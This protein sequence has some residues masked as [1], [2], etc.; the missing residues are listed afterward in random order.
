MILGIINK[1]NSKNSFDKCVVNQLTS[2]KNLKIPDGSSLKVLNGERTPN[3]RFVGFESMRYMGTVLLFKS[4]SILQY[5]VT[6]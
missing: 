6:F 2:N 3:S 5:L 4:K 1:L